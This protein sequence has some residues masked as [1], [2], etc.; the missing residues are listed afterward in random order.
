MSDFI[1]RRASTVCV[2]SSNEAMKSTIIALA[3]VLNNSAHQFLCIS[4][5][6][7]VLRISPPYITLSSAFFA[8]L[9]LFLFAGF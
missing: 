7:D 6:A 1:S 2:V 5:T 8:T 3:Y 9:F 4:T